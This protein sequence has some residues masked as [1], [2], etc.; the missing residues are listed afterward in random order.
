MT[1]LPEK[2]Y[3]MPERVEAETGMQ[4]QR[5]TIFTSNETAIIGKKKAQLKVFPLTFCTNNAL[6][7]R[8]FVFFSS[9]MIRPLIRHL[10]RLEMG[11][12]AIPMKCFV[13]RRST[14]SLFWKSKKK[15]KRNSES[16]VKKQVLKFSSTRS[17]LINNNCLKLSSI[18]RFNFFWPF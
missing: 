14:D 18:L 6:M 1:L 16:L 5:F 7:I 11:C 12:K 13:S 8:A 17:C 2:N 3:T 10:S 4:T 9:I 15:K